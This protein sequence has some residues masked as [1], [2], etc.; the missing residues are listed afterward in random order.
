MA[1]LELPEGW[2][3]AAQP[4]WPAIDASAGLETSRVWPETVRVV[5]L[6]VPSRFELLVARPAGRENAFA[7]AL[8]F[9][10]S[11]SGDI[12]LTCAR[13]LPGAPDLDKALDA[14]LSPQRT[15]SWWKKKALKDLMDRLT[16]EAITGAIPMPDETLAKA[17]QARDVISKQIAGTPM[18]RK[19]NRITR[20]DLEN[21]RDI[22]MGADA[23]PTQAVE[24]A[25][26]VSYATAANLVARARKDGLIGPAVRGKPD[27]RK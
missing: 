27:P 15:V 2:A 22:Y 21:V 19:R 5:G 9:T 17:L 8:E 12:T 20:K 14:L 24:R 11:D 10:A 3:S 6:P 1:D 13:A 25:L 16:S 4:G 7:I 18:S 23:K 26:Q